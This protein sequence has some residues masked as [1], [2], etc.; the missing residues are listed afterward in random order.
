MIIYITWPTCSFKLI[1]LAT[2][3]SQ[4][5]IGNE[6]NSTNKK[7][8]WWILIT[9]LTVCT[10][11]TH[12]KWLFW[13][14]LSNWSWSLTPTCIALLKRKFVWLPIFEINGEKYERF[15]LFSTDVKTQFYNLD[16]TRIWL[17]QNKFKIIS[18]D[19]DIRL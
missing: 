16:V 10:L 18:K 3:F 11:H 7:K 9:R 14:N 12:M 13:R 6:F 1:F 4:C 15:R 17:L 2:K 8:S 5:Q 19:Q